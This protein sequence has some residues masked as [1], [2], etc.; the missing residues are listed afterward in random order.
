MDTIQ[1][2]SWGEFGSKINEIKEKYPDLEK[3]HENYILYRG[4]SNSTWSLLTTLER[5]SKKIYTKEDYYRLMVKTYF[6]FRSLFGIEYNMEVDMSKIDWSRENDPNRGSI[7]DSYLGYDYMVYLRHH[8]FPSPLLDWSLS[9]YIAAYFAYAEKPQ[10]EYVSVYVYLERPEGVKLS[11]PYQPTIRLMGPY[12]KTHKRHYVQKA[13]YTIS[14]RVNES[15]VI[16]YCAH[17][18]SANEGQDIVYKINIPAKDRSRAVN[19]LDMYNIN[20]YTLF[21]T[22]EAMAKTLANEWLLN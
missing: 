18:F 17:D 16:E 20:H 4:Q 7:L 15:D 9:P 21:S 2:K 14:I 12:V 3:Y 19:E 1:L 6:R 22:E 10:S 5:A 11:N 13:W 8:G